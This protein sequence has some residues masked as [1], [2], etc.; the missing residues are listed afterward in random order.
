MI[1]RLP[2]VKLIAMV[3]VSMSLSTWARADEQGDRIK[4]LEQRLEANLQLVEKLAARVA[5]LERAAKLP[6]SPPVASSV[7]QTPPQ[8]QAQAQ[9]AQALSDLQ[10][11]VNQISEGLSRRVNDTGLP[12]HGFADVGAARSTSA[13][14]QRLKGFNI[15]TFELYLT[16]Q[17]GSR[18]KSL[19]ELAF[20][21]DQ[22]GHAELELERLQLGYALSDA[23]TVWGGRFHTPFGLWNTSFHHGANLQTSIFRPRFIDFED[24][25][26]IVPA[27]SV[28]VWVTG[29][30]ALGPGKITYDGYLT[31]GPRVR[32]R[33][34]DFNAFTDDNHG[35][36]L[37][38]NLGYQPSGPLN[39]LTL[40]LHG[41]GSSVDAYSTNS[42]V[43]SRTRLRAAGGYFG[44]DASEWEIIAEYYRF[45]NTDEG[46]G[47]RHSSSA[48]FAQIGKT[49]GSLTPFARY[50][51]TSLDPAD[52]YFLSQ[53]A[54]RS[55]KRAVLGVRYAID[56]RSSFKVE[57]SNTSESAV[58]Q[59]DENGL[60]VPFPG[61]SYRRAAFQYS[62]AF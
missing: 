37:G 30:T 49:F 35:K 45:A 11:S 9:Q 59:V 21:F 56:A 58:V 22:E 36:M 46:T 27:H 16:P 6:P 20:E 26:G 12:V 53:R 13:D 50:E 25:G 1:E 55:Y 31:N 57:L 62:I 41:F 60:P 18:V 17:F 47:I 38:F 28:G 24:K 33:T 34:L 42:S 40:G 44:Y 29:K 5:E 4:A 15:G 23:V 43:L 32:D 61:S 54:G 7:A 19:F 14:P 2:C 8:A 48:W 39:G 52:N 10:D 3:A 51:Q